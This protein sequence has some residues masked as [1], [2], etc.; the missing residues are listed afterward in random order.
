MSVDHGGADVTI[1]SDT[2]WYGRHYNIGAFVLNS[3]V[4]LNIDGYDGSSDKGWL[5]IEADTIDIQGTIYGKGKGYKGGDGGD[6][7]NGGTGENGDYLES[8]E[9][10]SSGNGPYG[11]AGGAG[12]LK[13]N[14]AGRNG[15]N[16]AD[17]GYAGTSVNGD[18]STDETVYMGSGGGGAGGGAGGHSGASVCPNNNYNGGG[19]AGGGAGGPGGGCLRLYANTSLSIS[20][21]IN[22]TGSLAGNGSNGTRP[23]CRWTARGYGGSG[24]SANSSGSSLGGTGGLGCNPG[25][26]SGLGNRTESKGGNG[27]TGGA[28]AGGGLL[29]KCYTSGGIN[30]SGTI[31]V[32]GGNDKT[33][34]AGTV[35]IFY[36]DSYTNTGT[37]HSGRTYASDFEVI[38]IPSTTFTWAFWVY[39]NDNSDNRPL[40][41]Y[42]DN[43]F[44]IGFN[45]NEVV[46][47]I[48][49]TFERTYTVGDIS[50]VWKHIALVKEASTYKLYID[51]S[52]VDTY[53]NSASIQFCHTL[54][55]GKKDSDYFNGRIDDL[56][57]YDEA[58]SAD[59]ISAIY[60][61]GSGTET[62]QPVYYLVPYSNSSEAQEGSYCMKVVADATD[63]LNQTLTRT[64]SSYIN[65]SQHDQIKFKVRASR[66]GSNFKVK[67]HDSG[68]T[69]TE[70]TPNIAAADTWQEET[71]D[72][73]GVSASD[74]D[75]I[76]KI[77]IEITDASADNTIY[78]DEMY[79]GDKSFAGQAYYSISPSVNFDD[80]VTVEWN[81]KLIT[82]YGDENTDSCAV[83]VCDG[84]QNETVTVR[85]YPHGIETVGTT[86]LF[87][88]VDTTNDFHKYRLTVKDTTYTLYMDGQKILT[89]TVKSET[90]SDAIQFG[91][92]SSTAGDNTKVEW[93]YFRYYIGNA[94]DPVDT[95][96]V[97]GCLIS[98]VTLWNKNLTGDEIST[99]YNFDNSVRVTLGLSWKDILW[100]NHIP[101]KFVSKRFGT[102]DLTTTST[103]YTQIDDMVYYI[104]KGTWSW[105]GIYTD[106]MKLSTGGADQK[107]NL[108]L[109][110]FDRDWSNIRTHTWQH[111]H[112]SGKNALPVVVTNTIIG[113]YGECK[114]APYWYVPT[115]STGTSV[116][117]GRIVTVYER[118][119]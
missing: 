106:A 89:G 71:W 85:Q 16:G 63:S 43:L 113:R 52:L 100:T 3:G 36:V 24:G 103:T 93:S 77:Q 74:K 102:S 28:G 45:Q 37:I 7:G 108:I 66:T 17:G 86:S 47:G 101:A 82:F 112:I 69:W 91:D 60:N 59:D 115:S 8:G 48:P 4:T 33:S 94:Y 90:T 35:K 64:L 98:E 9:N 30:I 114:V 50:G 46:Y 13:G 75:T 70:Y 25:Q 20:G 88:C 55:I 56:R 54:Y 29:I 12:G 116:G 1:S 97:A 99:L 95:S 39:R 83:K 40:I 73:S 27:G 44:Y 118:K 32:R 111:S 38:T 14:C 81:N 109:D 119:Y 26:E 104:S 62:D 61:S 67:I 68:G 6:G 96:S 42:Y 110:L 57:L 2:T 51:G 34:N 72:I 53:T 41:H 80:G 84:T 78:I 87:F 49:S 117:N 23:T 92:I 105:K 18:T 22:L 58:L 31:D 79:A 15:S 10:G 65:L 76:D 5:T 11:G 107:L 21:T 19:G